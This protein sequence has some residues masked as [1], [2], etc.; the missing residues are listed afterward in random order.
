METFPYN[1]ELG[2]EN[3]KKGSPVVFITKQKILNS[4]DF[5]MVLIIIY[6]FN[7]VEKCLFFSTEH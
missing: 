3:Y 4:Q 7:D 2:F 5:W 6:F 1:S